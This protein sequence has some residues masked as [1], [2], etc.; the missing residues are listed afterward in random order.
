MTA[1]DVEKWVTQDDETAP[2]WIRKRLEWEQEH[3]FDFFRSTWVN[4][5]E[6]TLQ[7]RATAIRQFCE[8]FDEQFDDIDLFTIQDWKE[9]LHI[10]GYGYRT[11][12]QKIY[13][14]SSFLTHLVN[15]D[16]L[17]SN[18][19]HLSDI[20]K[21]EKTNLEDEL[22]REYVSKPEYETLLDA[23]ETV[24]ER[25]ILVLLW[26]TGVRV[27]EAV[28]IQCKGAVHH[29]RSGDIRRDLQQIKILTSKT[30]KMEHDEDRNVY[31]TQKFE[32]VLIDWLDKGHRKSYFGESGPYLLVSEESEQMSPGTVSDIVREVSKRTDVHKEIYIDQSGRPRHWPHPHAFRKSYAVYRTKNG[33]PLAYLSDLMGHSSVDITKD[34]YLKFREDDIREADKQ[35]RPRL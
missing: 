11:V 16:I 13:A 30:A 21:W 27:G 33:M 28:N 6:K 17:N 31:Y 29:K 18:P 9:H 23:C 5:V 4:E 1:K 2:D 35:Y 22:D 24:R 12:R 10:E 26:D 8:W 20:D 32:N 14:L 7:N 3:L 34:K 19:V 25:L 15:K